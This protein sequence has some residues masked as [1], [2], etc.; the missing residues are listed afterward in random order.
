RDGWN[1]VED[2]LPEHN[3][4]S[5]SLGV[6]CLIFPKH[7]GQSTAFY[8]KRI[9]D[10]GCWYYAGAEVVGVTHWKEIDRPAIAGAAGEVDGG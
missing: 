4:K 1:S 5:G 2:R 8:G 10:R 6:E 9:K 3:K 7:N